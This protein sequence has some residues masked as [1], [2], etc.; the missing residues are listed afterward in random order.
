MSWQADQRTGGP[1]IN[2][3]VKEPGALHVLVLA[4]HP[5]DETIGASGVLARSPACSVAY[6]TDGAPRDSIFWT[7]GP[8]SSR[9]DYAK[10]RR[11]EAIRA[12][13]IAGVSEERIHWL[14]AVDQ[15]AVFAI[16]ALVERFKLLLDSSATNVVITH[17]YEGG[18]PDH[19]TAALVAH[20]AIAGQN[21]WI[22]LLEMTSYHARDGLCV[23]GEFLGAEPKA[24]DASDTRNGKSPFDLSEEDRD[25]KR[26]MLK[27]FVS[28]RPVLKHFPV[29]RELL[30]RAPNYDFSQPPHEGKLWYECMGWPMTGKRWRELAATAQVQEHSCH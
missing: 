30:R 12:L 23:T 26:Q 11:D 28:Q 2:Q 6:L 22:G 7:G 20:L 14:G 3:F 29:D 18:H 19:D 16:E 5:D 21:R 24:W 4:A 17:P 25:R 15:E 8:Y 13:R 1:P 10:V 27:E 9:S